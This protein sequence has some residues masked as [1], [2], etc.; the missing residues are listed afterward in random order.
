MEFI[1]DGNATAPVAV[2][3]SI[4]PLGGTLRKPIQALWLLPRD[5]GAAR[6]LVAP[7]GGVDGL[8]AAR[9]APVRSQVDDQASS[10]AV[11]IPSVSPPRTAN[12]SSSVMVPS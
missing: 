1:R 8:V 4:T 11:T 3:Y 2:E 9:R 6:L 12:R 7:E 5:G 10:R